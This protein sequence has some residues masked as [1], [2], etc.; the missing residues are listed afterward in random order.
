MTTTLLL[1]STGISKFLEQKIV[2]ADVNSTWMTY[3]G[4]EVSGTEIV[5]VHIFPEHNDGLQQNHTS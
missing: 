4:P 1:P 3:D 5:F 2:I